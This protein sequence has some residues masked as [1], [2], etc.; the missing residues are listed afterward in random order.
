MEHLFFGAATD[1]GSRRAAWCRKI[2]RPSRTEKLWRGT[3]RHWRVWLI[4]GVA[5]RLTTETFN[6]QHST[7]NAQGRTAVRF[8]SKLGVECFRGIKKPEQKITKG[9]KDKKPVTPM[10][11]M[12]PFF[13]PPFPSFPSVNTFFLRL[14]L[15]GKGVRPCRMAITYG[16]PVLRCSYRHWLTQGCLVSQDPSSLQD[17]ETLAGHYQTLACL[18]N[19]R[20]RFATNN[21]NIQ[22][23]TFNGER[24]R[25]YARR[26]SFEVGR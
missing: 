23:S 12:P 15:P 19:V 8:R 25:A 10:W 20:C 13:Q 18:A 17:G 6:A 4:S 3:T 24:P 11:G 26:S 21:G 2:H 7:P 22:L 9:T 14:S 1:T 5:S 16:T